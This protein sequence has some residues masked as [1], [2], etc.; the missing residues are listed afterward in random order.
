M[1]DESLILTLGQPM[2]VDQVPNLP[3]FATPSQG[4]TAGT[5]GGGAG[6]P[7]RPQS[8][9]MPGTVV[10]LRR[11]P[12][13]RDR[14]RGSAPR[15]SRSMRSAARRS[16]NGS[17]AEATWSSPSGATGRPSA[18]ACCARLLPALPA[19]QE[20]VTSLEALDT[21]AGSI[22]QI[23][24]PGTPPVM[25]TKLEEVEE[26]GGKVLSIMGNLPLVVRG[27]YG[28]GRVTLIAVGRRPEDLRRLARPRPLLGAGAGPEARP[29]RPGGAAA[30]RRRRAVLPVGSLRP[31]QPAAD[32]PG[33]VPRR[34]ADPLRLGR[35]LHLPVHPPDRP[36]RLPLPQEGAQADGADLDHLPDDRACR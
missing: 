11:G 21:F 26:R 32:R 35:L 13:D 29:A 15:S 25:V 9:L 23:T 24:P 30:G 20:R 28:F 3:G 34:E 5:R 1:P 22:K 17:S 12:G 8:G 33:A 10:R 18:T 36:G 31:R 4:R 2:G 6:G 14:H 27:P 16:S 19:G 7:G